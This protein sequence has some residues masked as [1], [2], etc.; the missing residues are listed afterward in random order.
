MT[1]DAS[2]FLYYMY[3]NDAIS[4]FG[5]HFIPSNLNPNFMCERQER[6]LDSKM[7]FTIL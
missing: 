7:I 6:H 1:L 4:I 2:I 3:K 5:D